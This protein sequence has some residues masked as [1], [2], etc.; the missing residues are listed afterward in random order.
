VAVDTPDED[1]RR[2]ADRV[3]RG[4]LAYTA[5]L[6]C[7]WLFFVITCRKSPFFGQYQI[8]A[9]AIGRVAV[10]FLVFSVLWGL[11]WC[12]VKNLLLRSLCGFSTEERRLAFRSRMEEPFDLS[13]LLARHS[14]RRIPIADASSEIV[15]SLFGKQKLRVWGMGDVNR[16]SLAGVFGGFFAA[17]ALCLWAVL[18]IGLPLP[19]VG[20]AVVIAASSTLLELSSPR[21]T[22]DFTMA[23]GNAL[24]CWAFGL[25]FY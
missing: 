13:G 21:G 2:T 8:D 1:R 5:A 3:F 14:E 23:T 24:L 11:V 7:F 18:A 17:L 12:G 25:L 10:G 20:L 16:K 9:E 22:D 19:W 15:G 4:A 6:T